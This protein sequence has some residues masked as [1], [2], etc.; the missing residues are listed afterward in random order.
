MTAESTLIP[1]RAEAS[2][3]R[4]RRFRY[5]SHEIDPAERRL[6]C[7]YLLDDQPFTETVTLSQGR[8]WNGPAAAEAARLVFLLSGVSY[9]KAGAPPLLELGSTPIR[10]A[11]RELLAEF[12]RAGL[13][14]F[15][16]RNGI[17]LR[18]ELAG[19]APA[20][21]P[22]P[23]TPIPQ[24]PL[25]PFGGGM[26][27][28]VTVEMVRK[29]PVNPRLF[30][31]SSGQAG[32]PG[33]E[34]AAAVSGLPVVRALR[35]LD[36][37]ILAPDALRLNGHVPVTGILSSIAVLAA[38]STG[39]SEVVMSNEQSAS[40]PTLVIEG[41]P[42]N[43]QF[44]KSARFENLFRRAL[45]GAF[46]SPPEYFS[47]L[48]SAGTPWIAER[49]ASLRQYHQSFRSCNRA[50]HIDPALRRPQWCGKCDKCCFVD[51]IL[52]AFME[53]SRLEEIFSGAEPLADPALIEQFAT[54]LGVSG[55]IKPFECVGDVDECRTAL[56]LATRRPDRQ[57]CPII[58]ELVR[59][60][61]ASGGD[62]AAADRTRQPVGPNNIPIEYAAAA[63]LG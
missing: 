16:Y 24:T 51:L 49:F 14:E 18:L 46:Q 34:E 29:L 11:E 28:I 50:F 55:Q 61:E 10:E 19:G 15:A 41:Q 30:I 1:P 40:V 2:T 21:R 37:A 36:P 23:F 7:H 47:L 53:R 8:G 63:G 22:A 5:L 48:R 12:Y 44:S 27:S 45:Q 39:S 20:G 57:D 25:I 17:E 42:I 9:Y 35:E 26:D 43:H 13:A 31:A 56:Q 6:V 33:L 54:L 3:P 60:I 62:R 52:A 4:A 38:V 32:Y 59:R 58:G